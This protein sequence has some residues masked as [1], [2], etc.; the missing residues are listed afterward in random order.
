[1][2]PIHYPKVKFCKDLNAKQSHLWPRRKLLTISQIKQ[3]QI[4]LKLAGINY[5]VLIILRPVRPGHAVLPAALLPRQPGRVLGLRDL[6]TF[7]D[8][9]IKRLRL[10]RLN[11]VVALRRVRPW[12]ERVGRV[13]ALEEQGLVLQLASQPK[14]SDIKMCFGFKF[15]YV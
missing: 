15:L 9:I 1:M 3:K 11:C 8:K 2:C 4:H 14:L 10:N 13:L 7:L 5:Q 6:L 12:S